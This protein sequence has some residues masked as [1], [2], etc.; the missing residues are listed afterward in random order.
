MAKGKVSSAKAASTRGTKKRSPV[1]ASK[2]KNNTKTSSRSGLAGRKKRSSKIKKA[3]PNSKVRYRMIQDA[4][5]YLAEEDG[6]RGDPLEYWLAA[7]KQI[8]V[9][10]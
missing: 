8:G 7:E 9:F 5:Y 6:F 2:A 1:A 10:A 3:A 4:A